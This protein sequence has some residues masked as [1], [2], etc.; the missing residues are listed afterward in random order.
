MSIHHIFYTNDKDIAWS[1]ITEPSAQIIQE[2]EDAHSY[3]YIELDCSETPI[4]EKYYINEAED[5]LVEFSTFVPSFTD[6]TPEID[7]VVTVTGVPSGTEVF[8]DGVSAGTMSDT[9]LTFTIKQAGAFKISLTKYR[10]YKYD[11]YIIGKRYGE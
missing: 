4:G 5:A 7:D 2:Q 6:V 1:T 9:T 3:S 10:Y 11:K 8:V